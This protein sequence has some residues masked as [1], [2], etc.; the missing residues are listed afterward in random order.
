MVRPRRTRGS[1]SLAG[2]ARRRMP[3]GGPSSPLP[4][5]P[6]APPPPP[7]P[8]GPF[9][10]LTPAALAWLAAAFPW[11]RRHASTFG[12]PTRDAADVAQAAVIAAALAWDTFVPAPELPSNVA[13]RRW[14]W[15]IM[16]HRARAY[17]EAAVRRELLD[18][19]AESSAGPPPAPGDAL[20]A[21]EVLRALHAATSPER[22]RVWHA[23]A[24]DGTPV[25]EIARAEGVAASTVYTWVREARED[26]ARAVARL[27]L[28]P[29]RRR[30]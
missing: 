2:R 6:G 23:W 5:P 24:V 9:A 29:V 1:V 12:V 27:D 17:R 28:R 8:G 30:R 19:A 11:L 18:P 16:A 4:P 25:G 21:R 14:A 20:E 3:A 22:W 7:P 26:M 15:G 10:H 13:R